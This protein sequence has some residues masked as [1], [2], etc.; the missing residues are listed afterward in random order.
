MALLGLRERVL[1]SEFIWLCSTCYTCQER[2]PQGVKIAD[3]MMALRNLA[4]RNGRLPEAYRVQLD[5][6]RT[7]GRLYEIDEFDNKRRARI[8]L[9][10]IPMKSDEVRAIF[11]MTGADDLMRA[12]EGVAK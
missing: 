3:L 9:P 1:A 11:E 2:C 7:N 8:G 4:A 12:G 5:L 6:I 10:E